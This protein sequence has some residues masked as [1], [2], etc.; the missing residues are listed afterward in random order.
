MSDS[1]TSW[2][3]KK[4]GT[5]AKS[6]TETEYVALTQATQEAIYQRKPLADL[7]YKADLPTV[8]YEDNQ[9]AIEISRDPRFHNRTKHIDVTSFFRERIASNEIIVVY[10]PSSDMLADIMT[11]GRTKN[12]FEKLGNSL[13]VYVC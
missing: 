5:V 13:N 3:S 11:R 7:G 6:T 8:L 1:T 4:Q 9:V 2:F 12:R 10:C